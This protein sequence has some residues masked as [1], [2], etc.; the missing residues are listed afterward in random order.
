MKRRS[1]ILLRILGWS[2]LSAPLLAFDEFPVGARP[3]ALGEAFTAVV[4]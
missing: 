4:R 2:L 1:G 3:A